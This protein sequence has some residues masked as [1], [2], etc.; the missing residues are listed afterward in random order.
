MTKVDNRLKP[1]S[2]LYGFGVG[3]RN[4]LFNLKLLKSKEFDIPV[5]GVGNITV[6]GTGKTPCVEYLVN[7]LKN[8][9]RLAVLSRGYKRKSKGF[10]IVNIDKHRTTSIDVG[11]ESFQMKSKFP[12]VIVAV[13]EK[14]VDGIEKLLRLPEKPELII[15]DDCYQ[16]R[17]VKPG[18]NILLI[19]YNRMISEDCLLPA[20]RLREPASNRD[21]ADIIIVTKC[22][23]DMKPID[24]RVLTKTVD[25]FPYQKL[26][27]STIIY[28]NLRKG[29]TEGKNRSLTDLENTNVL[30]LSGIA[31]PEQLHEDLAHYTSKIT[32]LFFPDHHDFNDEDVKKINF[33]FAGMAEPKLVITTEKDE[34]RLKNTY[35]LSED[36]KDHLYVLPITMQIINEQEDKFR[37]IIAEYANINLEPVTETVT[38]S[39]QMEFLDNSVKDEEQKP[40]VISFDF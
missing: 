17:Y 27:F 28:E 35:G 39:I 18:L 25:T 10:V 40:Q 20:G 33:T 5:I 24:F 29:L 15:L 8:Y 23:A 22:P 31:T 4:E 6:G 30:L 9:C 13:D 38:N 16:H 14:R 34:V 26:F 1:L 2:W 3:V 36:V 7:L 19:D 37:K 32:P 11:D 12:D 21:R